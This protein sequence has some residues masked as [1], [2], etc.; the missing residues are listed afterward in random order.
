[1]CSIKTVKNNLHRHTIQLIRLLYRPGKRL[2]D[3]RIVQDGIPKRLP[4]L[5]INDPQ[6]K[7]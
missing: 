6:Q 5:R 1:M 7:I 2:E 3:S 4:I